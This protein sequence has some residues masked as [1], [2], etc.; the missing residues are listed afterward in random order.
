MN[1]GRRQVRAL[2]VTISQPRE[3]GV[4]DTGPPGPRSDAMRPAETPE[5]K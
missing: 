3:R 4:A 2:T 5:A 1:F